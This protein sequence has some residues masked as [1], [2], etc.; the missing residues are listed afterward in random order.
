[1]S[2]IGE[3]ESIWRYPVKSMRGETLD[4]IFVSFAGVMGDRLYGII[5]GDGNRAFPWYTIRDYEALLLY[6]PR[7]KNHSA[8]LQ[9]ENLAAAQKMPPGINSLYP[10]QNQ[11]SVEVE[12]PDSDV[13]SLENNDFLD[14]LKSLTGNQNLSLH[15]S[16]R[17]QYDCRPLSIFSV[18]MR[19]LLVEELGMNID[20]RQ[21]RANFYVK[22]DDQSIDENDLVGHRLKIGDRLEINVLERDPRC[23][24]ITVNP[25]TAAVDSKLIKHIAQSHEGYAGVYGAVLVEGMVKAGDRIELLSRYR[26]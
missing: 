11:F 15:F 23:K 16:Q 19:D 3:I 10:D 20:K 9:P 12:T 5:N 22:W 7:Y 14:H 17:S 24:V 21:F 6:Q 1:M 18:E 8:T 4:E 13:Y 2:P 26:F 25:D